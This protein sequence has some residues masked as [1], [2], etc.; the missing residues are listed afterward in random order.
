MKR[1]GERGK[2]S[3]KLFYSVEKRKEICCSSPSYL[4]FH[5]HIFHLP[6]GRL[7]FPFPGKK[8]EKEKEI[9]SFLNYL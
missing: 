8:E 2:E 5:T 3:L 4:F 7:N 1:P 9:H 6:P